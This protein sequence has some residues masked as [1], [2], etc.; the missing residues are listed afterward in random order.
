MVADIY[1]ENF[2][3]AIKKAKRYSAT[4]KIIKSP[5]SKVPRDFPNFW[6]NEENKTRM[7]ELLPQTIKQRRLHLLN[8]PKTPQIIFLHEEEHVS[9]KLIGCS[10][11]SQMLSNHKETNIKFI[12]VKMETLQVKLL[13]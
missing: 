11:Y 7:I 6:L 4:N 13:L 3:T 10:A 2:I 12:A 8:A 1:F 5:K 9:L